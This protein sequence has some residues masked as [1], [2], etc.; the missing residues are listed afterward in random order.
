MNIG[1]GRKRNINEF[2][3]ITHDDG[4]HLFQTNINSHQNKIFALSPNVKTVQNC[5]NDWFLEF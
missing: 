4:C 3:T 5:S 2:G 1:N